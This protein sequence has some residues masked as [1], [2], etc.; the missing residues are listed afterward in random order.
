[1]TRARFFFTIL[2]LYLLTACVAFG[3][4]GYNA[5]YTVTKNTYSVEEGFASHEIFCGLQDDA[6]FLWFGTRNGINRFDGKQCLLFTRQRNQLQ[7]N[8]VVQ[9]AKDDGNHLFVVYGSSGFQLSANGRVDVMDV[10]TQQVQSLTEMFPGMPFRERDVYWVSNDGTDDVN[11]LT[12]HPYRLWK[13]SRKKGFRLRYEVKDWPQGNSVAGQDYRTSG[14]LCL[15]ANGKALLKLHNQLPQYL[16]QEDTVISFLQKDALRSLPLGFN[17]KN[18]LVITY[19]TASHRDD[20]SVGTVSPTG[21][22][23]LPVK[24]GTIHADSLA[25]KYWYQAS[26]AGNGSASVL[27][28]STDALYLWNEDMY[29]KII[30]RSELKNFENLFLY[31]LFPDKLGNLW[32]C[33]SLGVFQLKIE[34][35]RFTTYFTQ[36]QQQVETN[37]QARGIYA[38]ASGRVAANIWRHIFLQQNTR[39]QSN[40]DS[41]INYALAAHNGVLYG[42]ANHLFRYDD[43]KNQIIQYP[44]GPPNDIW[45][46]ASLNDSNL[47]LGRTNGLTVFNTRSEKTAPLQ[48]NPQSIQEPRF[49]YRFLPHKKDSLWAVAENGLYSLVPDGVKGWRSERLQSN[50]LDQLSLFDVY[51]DSSGLFWLATNGEGLWQWNWV[52]NSFRQFNITSGLPSDVLYRIEADDYDN[53][54]I[55]SDY[56]LIRFNKKSLKVNTYSMRDG[57]SNNEFNRT[58]SFRAFD[59][60]LFFGGLNGVNAFYPADF[61]ADT[62][63]LNVPL[64]VINFSQF[65]AGEN[66]LVNKTQ[67]LLKHHRI[68][69]SPGD[70]FFTLQFQLLNFEKDENTRYAYKIE[71][72]DQEWNYINENSIR[73]SGLPYGKVVLQVKA[74]NGQG[75]W[76]HS[77]LQIPVIVLKPYYLQWWFI[78]LVALAFGGLLVALIKFRTRRL[79]AEKIKLEKTVSERTMQLKQSLEEQAQLL[80]EKD[81]LMKEIHHRVKNNLQVISGLLELQSKTLTDETAIDAL[82]EGRNRVKSMALIHQNL[83]QFENLSN[84]ELK[85][86]VNDLCRQVETV[87]RKQQSVTIQVRV[88]ELYLDID[89][90]VPLGLILN[91]LLTNSFKY[92]FDQK[93]HGEIH[94]ALDV[95]SPGRYQLQYSDNGPGLPEGFVIRDAAT[96]GLQLVHDLSRQIGG[97]VRYEYR[98]GACYFINFTNRHVRKNQD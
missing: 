27:Y 28:I 83:Y 21:L 35:N 88:P 44:D 66:K 24:A 33:T 91:E 47:V 71:G 89:T 93:E 50:V 26:C 39:L 38:D 60:R 42:G 70:P 63:S 61:A 32:L 6:G 29:L 97:H 40:T 17:R 67:D 52:N 96:L 76:S 53:L 54:W 65:V 86:F 57:L 62:T 48:Y 81:V 73:I 4:T 37:N 9:L 79:A 98:N 95:E 30:D 25:G 64:Q 36:A 92:A 69:L 90:A 20:F 82:T 15:F 3:Q 75:A 18:E 1:M 13:Y 43:I 77:A 94:I 84:I 22:A 41:N 74:Q 16:V 10:I 12:A 14:P 72:L 46:I 87:F 58:S 7:D 55:S 80:T 51:I 85:R 11:F 5:G 59:G 34:K 19:N 78:G 49:V 8:K 45:S 23:T 2:L 68:Q 31:Q 56:G